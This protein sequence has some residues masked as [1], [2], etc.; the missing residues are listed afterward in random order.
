MTSLKSGVKMGLMKKLSLYLFLV[1]MFCNV[2]FAEWKQVSIN[3]TGGKQ[4]FDPTSIKKSDGYIQVWTMT[5]Y[6]EPDPSGNYSNKILMK[7]D[8]NNLGF[9][10]IEAMFYTGH[11]GRGEGLSLEPPD[12]WGQFSPNSVGEDFVKLVCN[13]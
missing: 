7:I 13:L 6:P 9:K 4:Y 10:F 12:E 8:C 11:M 2:G 5:D 1:L 3:D